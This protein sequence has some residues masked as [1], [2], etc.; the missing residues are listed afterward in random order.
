MKMKQPL[1]FRR[2]YSGVLYSVL[3][4]CMVA[5]VGVSAYTLFTDYGD[6]GDFSIPEVSFPSINPDNVSKIPV[7]YDVS[8]VPGTIKPPET[9]VPEP[10]EPVYVNPCSGAILKKYSMTSLVFSQTMKD[11]R[12]H[13]GIDIAGELYSPVYA[14]TDG[15][16]TKIYEDAFMG[17]VVVIEHENALTT[18]YMNLSAE[19]PTGI[20]VGKYV[21]AG[22]IIGSIG[23]TALAEISDKPHLHLEMRVDGNLIDPLPELVTE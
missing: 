2:V 21:L 7:G 22:D 12:T 8:G 20:E 13:S 16:V 18:H 11:H 15:T 19:I 23:K 6:I 10:P 1:S 4:V 5:V 17:T 14:Y 9:S 3:A